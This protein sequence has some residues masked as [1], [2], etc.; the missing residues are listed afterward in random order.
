MS[1]GFKINRNH[2]DGAP[3]TVE[4]S[5]GWAE[6]ATYREIC[7]AI[8]YVIETSIKRLEMEKPT[9]RK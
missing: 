4:I 6:T 3:V 2:P 7:E 9:H 1:H 5:V 8:N